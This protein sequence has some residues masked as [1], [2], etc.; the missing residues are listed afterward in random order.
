MKIGIASGYFNPLHVGHLDYLQESRKHCDKLVV[1]VNSDL[2]VEDKGSVPFMSSV[3]R[4][5]IVGALGCVD[6]VLVSAS[7]DSTVCK[8]IEIVNELFRNIENEM[9]FFNSGD[10]DLDSTPEM[11]V[12]TNLGLSVM[13]LRQ[14][15]IESSSDLLLKLHSD[16]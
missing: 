3:D 9:I 1:I 16:N 4:M 14:P 7:E 13:I 12:C 8:D 15:K 6:L 2:Q 5:R 10:R 11:G